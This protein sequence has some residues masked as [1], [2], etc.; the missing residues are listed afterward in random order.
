MPLYRHD[1]AF[2][3]ER[4]VTV[5]WHD[6][7]MEALQQGNSEKHRGMA[8]QVSQFMSRKLGGELYRRLC[9]HYAGS[10]AFT[11][12]KDGMFHLLMKKTFGPPIMGCTEQ[13]WNIDHVDEWIFVP[14]NNNW[15]H[16]LMVRSPLQ[17]KLNNS[18]R[19]FEPI[20][21][22]H[23]GPFPLWLPFAR[24][25]TSLDPATINA[26]NFPAVQNGLIQAPLW[27]RDGRFVLVYMRGVTDAVKDNFVINFNK[28]L[29]WLHRQLA[30]SPSLL[31]AIR[32]HFPALNLLEW[33]YF[34]KS[35]NRAR[36]LGTSHKTSLFGFGPLK[37]TV[38]I[39]HSRRWVRMPN[40]PDGSRRWRQELLVRGFSDKTVNLRI[41]DYE[42]G[43]AHG[44]D[45]AL[46][47][48]TA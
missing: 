39:E 18:A 4:R 33:A 12:R 2:I 7:W 19:A 47:A 32:A 3:L 23:R 24:A 9:N 34:P 20:P 15:I 40:A 28:E 10:F 43:V 29:S 38:E 46:R 37:Y 6:A 41:S 27:F 25:W 22:R 26:F 48:Y 30:Q 13:D 44:W 45:Q 42:T 8:S 21:F 14:A 16:R 5:A 36:Y 17:W 1:N 11:R 31:A 35:G